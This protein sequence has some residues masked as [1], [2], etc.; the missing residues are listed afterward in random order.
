[1]R[2]TP[3]RVAPVAVL[4]AAA[5]T[6]NV[7][8]AP[9]LGVRGADVDAPTITALTVNPSPV[10]LGTKASGR[11]SFAIAVR[12]VDAGGVDR[13]TVGVYDP[14]DRAGRAYRLTR[15]SG[16]AVDGLWTAT[17]VLPNLAKRGAW[18][19]R[20]FATDRASNTTNPDRVYTNFRVTLPTRFRGVDV[21]ADPST[22]AISG[23]ATLQRFRPGAGWVPFSGRNVMLEFQPEGANGFLRVATARTASDGSVSFDRISANGSGLWR[24]GYAGN[25]GYAPTVSGA[26]RVTITPSPSSSP[27]SADQVNT[28]SARPEYPSAGNSEPPGTD[29]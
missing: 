14:K 6:G 22:G 3:S 16:S 12:A 17:L 10:V 13:V 8:S 19:V 7:T 11:T 4:T 28:A 20:A 25:T 29:Q 18:A 1:M 2:F 23:V 26:D 5:L 15:T 27:A 21:Q 9:A 24:A